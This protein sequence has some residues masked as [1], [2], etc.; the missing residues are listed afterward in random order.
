LILDD[1]SAEPVLYTYKSVNFN[2][3]SFAPI[4]N[5]ATSVSVVDGVKIEELGVDEFKATVAVPAFVKLYN[6][7][8]FGPEILVHKTRAIL[9]ESLAS[10]ADNFNWKSCPVVI[11]VEKS[12]R[13]VTSTAVFLAIATF[14]SLKSAFQ[15]DIFFVETTVSPTNNL[16]LVIFEVLTTPVPARRLEA[17]VNLV[18]VTLE[19]S[20]ALIENFINV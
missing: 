7:P 14:I 9:L 1:K 13:T 17:N 20:L 8:G 19:T 12:A 4:V 11:A 10:T 15:L 3:S 16:T 18:T 5:L 2:E 6:T